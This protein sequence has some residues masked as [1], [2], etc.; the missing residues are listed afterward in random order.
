MARRASFVVE[1]LETR[2]SL[3]GVSYSL[4][5]DQ[6]VYSVGEPIQMTFTET[7]TGDQPVTVNVGPGDFIV[8]SQGAFSSTWESNPGDQGQP[9]TVT[10]QPGQSYAQTATWDGTMTYTSGQRIAQWGTFTLSDLDAPQGLTATFQITDPL[11]YSLTTDQSV[12]Q[13]G[14]PI[15]IT[16][17]ETNTSDEPVLVE[18]GDDYGLSVLQNA[19]VVW[20]PFEAIF[21]DPMILAPTLPGGLIQPIPWGATILQ[22]GDS[23]SD[24]STWDGIPNT[25]PPSILSGSFTVAAQL[26]GQ[27][28]S[29]TF[30]IATPPAAQ[31]TTSL[32]TDQS[33][34]LAGD[35]IQMTFTETNTGDLPTTI[36]VGGGFDVMQ[37]GNEVWSSEN[38]NQFFPL[39]SFWGGYGQDL[40]WETLQPGQSYTQSVTWYG[41]PQGGSLVETG[42]FVVSHEEDPRQSSATF[43]IGGLAY[44]LTTDQSVYQLGEPVQMTLTET[45]T[46][47]Q[48]MIIDPNL[49]TFNI[50]QDG[51]WV[52]GND[53]WYFSQATVTLQ[54]GQSYSHTVTWDGVPSGA[55]YD[56]TLNL[57]GTFVVSVPGLPQQATFQIA[58]PQIAYSLTT[59]QP[60]YSSGE[61]VQMI[62]TE[63]NTGDQPVTI[64]PD[65]LAFT[66]TQDGNWVWG[67]FPEFWSQATVTLQPGQS[68]SQ[69][70][71]W[72]GFPADAPYD[73]ALNPS[74]TFVVSVAGVSQQA[75]FQV[76]DPQ[77]AYSLTTD[78]PTYESGEPVQMIL[79]E[80]NTGDQPVTIDPD[81]LAFTITQDGNLVWEDLPEFWIQATVT[82]QPGQSYAQTV[83]WDGFSADAP[84]DGALNPSGTFVVSVAGVSQQATFQIAD[85]QIAYSLTTDQPIYNSGE[86]VQMILTET[87]MGDQ[88]VTIDPDLL[89]FTITLDGNWVW[90]NESEFCSQTT[91]TLQPGQSYAQTVTWD[92]IPS[93]A[94]YDGALNPSGTFVVSVTGTSQQATF[95]VTDPQLVYSL[96]TDQSVYDAGELVH[97]MFTETNTGSQ[98]VTIDPELI[99]LTITLDGFNIW[100]QSSFWR[101]RGP[102]VTLQPGESYTKMV[103]WDGDTESYWQGVPAGAL[104]TAVVSVEGISPQAT[105][106]IVADSAQTSTQTTDDP[107]TPPPSST[108]TI[109]VTTTPAAKPAVVGMD[110]LN[111]PT[112]AFRSSRSVLAWS[113][114]ASRPDR[115]IPLLAF[116]IVRPNQAIAMDS[117]RGHGALLARDPG[118]Q[119]FVTAYI[120]AKRTP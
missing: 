28:V 105:F 3:S 59:D 36:L 16:L 101:R 38:A 87:N 45:N 53:S 30:Q 88:P 80:T 18:D 34:Y 55:P 68:C 90:G 11:S 77:I 115:G 41:V 15:Q 22:P 82:L 9:V 111:G 40:H 76:A 29:S 84:Y 85:P 116:S 12:Y 118:D 107:A 61:P 4:T 95:Q 109:S 8:T 31:I 114:R 89:A 100:A 96:T 13:V 83:T 119:S 39:V 93:D 94:P 10:L 37:N 73:G 33:T 6:S 20:Q 117:A 23:Y 75:T 120:G 1:Q 54:P 113:T 51:N 106:Q 25:V 103:T 32:T 17:N 27:S 60:T 69:T 35:P 43:Q 57:W 110:A 21:V 44:S 65:L 72:D 97:M 62:L 48:P 70:V 19:V 24:T 50:T 99:G 102:T 79:T 46:S 49:V 63:T 7:N 52:W 92:G 71:T 42:T 47:N 81:L 58:D 108:P 2:A 112:P 78:Q 104:G 66:I 26:D 5:T 74:G 91:V 67:N 14:E 64:D 56:G 86:P 98:P